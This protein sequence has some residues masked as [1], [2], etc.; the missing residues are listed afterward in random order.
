ME[1]AM[2]EH[3]FERMMDAVR[4]AIMVPPM[5]D[6]LAGSL[7]SEMSPQAGND[8]RIEQPSPVIPFPE[9]AHVA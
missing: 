8:N 3:D 7:M 1:R 6:A 5:E 2:S 4:M 9:G